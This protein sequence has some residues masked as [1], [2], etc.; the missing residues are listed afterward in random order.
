MF[1][2]IPKII[3]MMSALFGFKS[4]DELPIDAKNMALDLTDEMKAKL[5]A[6][7]GKKYTVEMLNGVN[8]EIKA[9]MS[10]DM[11]IKAIQDEL[12][13]LV[14][15]DV[16]LNAELKDA[17]AGDN[18]KE[19]I[20]QTLALISANQTSLREKNGELEAQVKKLMGEGVGDVPEAVIHIARGTMAKHSQTHLHASNKPW[21]AFEKRSWNARLRD[22][23]IKATDFSSDANIPLLQQDLEHF[24]RENPNGLN[25]LFNDFADLPAEW[26]RRTGVLDRIAD[27]FIIPAEI[28]QGRAKGWK[29]KGK[30]KIDAEQGRVFRKKIDITFD[31]YELQEIENTWIRQYNAN[32]GSHPWKMSFIGFLL[33]E[34]I[35]RQKLDDRRAQINGI[36]AQTPEG[37]GIP[38][39]AVNSQDGLRFLFWYY[40]DVVKKYKAVDLGVPTT[41]NI[42]DY[43]RSLI[44]SIPEDERAESGL[45]LGLSQAW[46]D[47]YRVRAGLVYQ[48]HKNTDSGSARY[49]KDYPIDYPNIM[50]QPLKDMTKTDFMYITQ[51]NNIQILDYNVSEK[52]KFTVTHDKR[53]TN[54]FADYR[55][56][57]RLKYVGTKLAANDPAEFE[58]Q[59]VWS[60]SVPVFDKDTAVPLFDDATGIINFHYSTMKVDA[61]WVTDITE[62]E[63]APKG[64]IIKIIGNTSLL[65]NKYVKDGGNFDL[66]GNADFNLKSGGTLTLRVEDDGTFKEIKRTAAPEAAASTDVNF[67]T[68]TIDA[69]EGNVFRN[70]AGANTT[71]ASIIN[72]TE[73]KTIRIYGKTGIN[74]IVQDVATNIEVATT[75]TLA[76]TTDYID[77]TKIDG[78][79]YEVKRLIA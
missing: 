4:E 10:K 79:W 52:G 57:I 68:T 24:V 14:R 27:G 51:S 26:D 60:N 76:A 50:F 19:D 35:K 65:A 3:A 38:G 34:L 56:G 47:A 15:E 18:P 33:G 49:D 2:N 72:G 46:L 12:A 61:A 28:V 67:N 78:V 66:A 8:G 20:S 64:A 29:P 62:M 22:G 21:D 63:N 55:L 71:I 74:T 44:L 54:I 6:H 42:V 59:K 5:E 75:A 77:L 25:S 69:N 23:S 36:F 37:D 43:V 53:D 40:R 11:D 48:M 41:T 13:A 32:D 17:A 58:R 30:F 31:G 70:V 1:K 39:A 9:F 7:F 45:E 73:G 16:Q